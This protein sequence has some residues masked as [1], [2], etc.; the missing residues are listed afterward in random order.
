MYRGIIMSDITNEILTAKEVRELREIHDRFRNQ[1][2]RDKQPELPEDIRLKL[3]AFSRIQIKSKLKQH[4]RETIT[5]EGRK[6]TERGTINKVYLPEL[7][8]YQMDAAQMVS[9][10]GKEA[11]RLQ[12]A[13][14]GTPEFYNEIRYIIEEGGGEQTMSTILEKARKFTIYCLAIGKEL[15][16]DAKYLSTKTHCLPNN[17]KYP[18]DDNDNNKDLFLSS[19]VIEKIQETNLNVRYQEIQLFS[20]I[21]WW[22]QW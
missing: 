1:E 5:F 2:L 3:E 11:D 15:D 21:K 22:I 6:W 9:A 18:E 17:L 16:R 10:I 12:T 20:K 13:E 14:Q 8:K 19:E 4:A 7:K